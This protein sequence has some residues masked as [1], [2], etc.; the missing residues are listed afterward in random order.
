MRLHEWDAIPS[1]LKGR[2]FVRHTPV[3]THFRT[4]YEEMHAV[5]HFIAEHLNAGKGPRAVIVPL[6][7]Y[8]MM[9]REGMP[10]YDELANRGYL[11]A[12]KEELSPAVRLV[13]IDYHINDPQ[14]AAATV[15][16]FLEFMASKDSLPVTPEAHMA[17]RALGGVR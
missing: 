4:T 5:G 16:L 10:L 14:C 15:E 7:G 8:S 11:D 17:S 1:D 6:R 3:H 2:P 12:L 13:E 9:N